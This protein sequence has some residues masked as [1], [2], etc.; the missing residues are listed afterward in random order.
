MPLDE[1]RD[2]YATSLEHVTTR[3]EIPHILNARRLFG[4]GVEIGV[5]QGIYSAH[6]LENWRGAHLISVD[7]WIEQSVEDYRDIAAVKQGT[8]DLFYRRTIARLARYRHRNT[9]WRLTSA[10]GADKI[11]HHS[12]DFVF[13]DAR[14]DYQSVKEDLGL[15]ADKVRPGGLLAGH[16]FLDARDSPFGDY[17]VRSAVTEFCAAR[18]LRVDAT[19]DDLPFCSWLVAVPMPD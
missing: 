13:I 19:H 14:H 5:Q 6:L 3:E 15:W 18:D 2:T 4:C 7:P 9:I 16:D 8:H 11:P 10:E 17:G 1:A 12:L